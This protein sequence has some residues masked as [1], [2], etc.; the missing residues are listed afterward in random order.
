MRRACL[1]A[2]GELARRDPR[3][4]FIGSDIT[5]QNLERFAA[6]LPDRFFM[7]GIYEGHV[8]GMA[9]GLALCGKVPYVNTIA[10]FLTRRCYE[11]IVI[12]LALH[13]LPV[14]LLGSGGGTVYAP[15]GPTHLANEDIAILRAVPNMTIVA[16][17]DADEMRRLMP[18]T[19][20]WSGPLYVRIAKGGD[21]TVS[22][23]AHPFAIGRAIPLREG[24]TVLFVTTGVVTQMAV[25]A[26]ADLSASGISAGVLHVHTV[27]PL[28]AEAIVARARSAEVVITAEEHTLAGGLGSAVAEAL[29]EAGRTT[30]RF[31]RLGFPDVFTDELGSQSQIMARYGLSAAH[32]A[33]RAR[34]LLAQ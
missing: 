33:A 1:L 6:E 32:L 19:L 26:A 34:E 9:A 20:D 24:G 3:V 11:Q 30:F 4:V 14:R 31:A 7:E 8:V 28:D 5:K 27:K 21:A 18:L 2:L 12:D 10:T 29:L 17:C 13:R 15:L 16:P 23:D 25:T 22:S